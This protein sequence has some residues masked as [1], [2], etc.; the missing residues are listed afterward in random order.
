[1]LTKKTTHLTVLA[2]DA[3]FALFRQPNLRTNTQA[4]GS[5]PTARGHNT[6]AIE[7]QSGHSKKGQ[8][9][10]ISVNSCHQPP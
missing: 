7:T 5:K 2:V 4:H 9:V 1:M 6:Q 10:I 3:L 8:P